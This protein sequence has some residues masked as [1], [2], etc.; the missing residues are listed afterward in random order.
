MKITD[1]QL[2]VLEQPERSA[3]TYSLI[4]VPQV[5]RTQYAHRSQPAARPL[6]Q[7]F[8]EVRTSDGL[9][10]RCD[11]DMT[12]VQL[13]I[14]RRHVIGQDP[15][16]REF[17]FQMLHKGTRWV[18]QTPGWFGAFD[19]CLW[20]I[21]GQA[22]GLPVHALLGRLR[23]RFPAYLTGGD[24]TAADYLR[25]IDAGRECGLQAYKL[26]TYKGGAAD[27]P[28]LR[29]VR[30]GA[31]DEY[32]L[33]NDPVCSYTLREA[34]EVG[35]V[36]ED[37]NYLWLEEPMPEQQMHLYQELCRAL[38]MPVMSTERLMHDM[39]LTAQWL[40]QGATDR[41][42]A[43]AAYGATQVPKLAHFAELHGAH[44]E[45]NGPGGLCGLVHAH[46]GCCLDNT[47]YYEFTGRPPQ[48]LADQGAQWGLVNA[49]VLRDGHVVPPDGPGWGAEWDEPAYARRIAAQ[50]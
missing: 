37:L 31:G 43:R 25:A 18:Y 9:R 47:D 49:P 38:V 11:T 22:A 8:L 13:D 40:I 12:P 5:R 16:R 24:G 46:L 2:V 20:D 14:L 4:R 45:L 19:N 32:V 26:H 17:L 42:R 6:Q 3:S 27:I 7:A 21:A 10:S 35:R 44:V 28:L 39:D 15:F 36:M 34:I 29:E 33:I 30:R 23:D 48:A 50:Y 1:V 41:L